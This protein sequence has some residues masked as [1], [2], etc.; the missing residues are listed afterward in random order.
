MRMK[1]VPY[2]GP[3]VIGLLRKSLIR[4][5]DLAH[6]ARDWCIPARNCLVS[7]AIWRKMES[8]RDGWVGE[9]SVRQ[10]IT[11][12]VMSPAVVLSVTA[13]YSC[14]VVWCW[15][16]SNWCSVSPTSGVVCSL[17]HG[18]S[19][20]FWN[21]FPLYIYIYRCVVTV[22]CVCWPD[23]LSTAKNWFLNLFI[24]ERVEVPGLRPGYRF[25]QQC[26]TLW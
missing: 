15:S 18:E 4:P 9:I 13:C 12:D 10:M 5:G 22:W 20:F 1:R 24:F 26:Y 21:C 17:R 2:W 7:A 6:G 14:S 19:S 3:T 11:D 23:Q 16:H 8:V 25:P